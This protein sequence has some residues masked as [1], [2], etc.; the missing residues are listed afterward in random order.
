MTMEPWQS[1]GI[2]S[3]AGVAAYLYY[4]H[5]RKLK[6]GRGPLPSIGKSQTNE[7]KSVDGNKAQRKRAKN[8]DPVEKSIIDVAEV[9]AASVSTTEKGLKKRK[10][11]KKPSGPLAQS[12]AVDIDPA[13][14]QQQDSDDAVSDHV[15]N[16]EFARQLS[17]LKAG[18]TL[19]KPAGGAETRKTKK[20]GKRDEAPPVLV[21]GLSHPGNP[22]PKLNGV[23]AASSTTGADADDDLS[24]AVSPEFAATPTA[25]SAGDI[26]DMLEVP[27]KGPSVLRLTASTESLESRPSRASKPAQEPET[28]KQRQNRKKNE[29]KKIARE[30]EE[31]DRRVRLEKQLRTAREAEGR[32]A[33]NGLGSSQ[34]PAVNAW[35]KLGEAGGRKDASVTENHPT[36][37]DTFDPSKTGAVDSPSNGKNGSSADQEWTSELPSEEEQ[38]RL[39]TELDGNGWNTVKKNKAK[40]KA[41]AVGEKVPGNDNGGSTLDG[42]RLT[43]QGKSASGANHTDSKENVGASTN[44]TTSDSGVDVSKPENGSFESVSSYIKRPT[45][46]LTMWN[47]ENIHKHPD[48]DSRFPLAL[49]GHP[50]DSDWAVV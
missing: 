13:S 17:G 12:S 46:D 36:L 10:A 31:K 37:L 50:E 25:T 14:V 5:S 3:V 47:R 20:P 41:G 9:S 6:R 23:S 1:W 18:S 15:D 8:S 40:K 7:F 19:N 48:Y 39:L 33:K 16:A 34:A 4:S 28:K 21:N 32:P 29:E 27:K 11:T 49:I 45:I 22:P 44:S 42:S 24:P 26:S 43:T 30:Q 38:M 35:D 2:V